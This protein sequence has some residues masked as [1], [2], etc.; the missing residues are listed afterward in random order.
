MNQTIMMILQVD[1]IWDG[2]ILL[3]Q[4]SLLILLLQV[5][6]DYSMDKDLED[7]VFRANDHI[8]CPLITMTDNCQVLSPQADTNIID[9]GNFLKKN[10]DLK[11]YLEFHTGVFGSEQGNMKWSEFCATSIVYTLIHEHGVDPEQ[12]V[13][14]GRGESELLVPSEEIYSLKERA[15]QN[16]LNN[17]NRRILLV[18]R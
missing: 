14:I 4:I 12:I 13:G 17:C 3:L 15:D 7:T 6:K 10:S 11:F 18:V 9:I 8:I 16:E 2:Y 1:T 5:H